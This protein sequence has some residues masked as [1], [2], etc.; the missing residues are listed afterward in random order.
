MDFRVLE[1]ATAGSRKTLTEGPAPLSETP[2]M[3]GLPVNG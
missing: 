3:P 2:K 1:T